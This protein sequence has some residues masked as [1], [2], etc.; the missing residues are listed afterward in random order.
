[1]DKL[2]VMYWLAR[3]GGVVGAILTGR[4]LWQDYK[5]NRPIDRMTQIGLVLSLV[6]VA[7]SF[8]DAV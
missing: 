6:L 4:Y 7:I 8:T 3:I 2:P 5:A 1:M